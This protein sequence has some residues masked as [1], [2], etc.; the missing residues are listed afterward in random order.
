MNTEE[1]VPRC[2]QSNLDTVSMFGM[3]INSVTLSDVF[4]TVGRQIESREPGY[5]LT[6]NIDHVCE[7]QENAEF[8]DVYRNGFLVLA[9]GMP[10][11]WASK[12][13]GK[14]IKEKISG[15]DLVYW[16]SEYAAQKGYSIFFFGANE[17]IAQEASEILNEKYPNLKIA[18]VYFPPMGLRKAS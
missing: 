2:A 3:T 6:P 17:G 11:L 14:P 10:I 9:D 5:I 1:T 8:R 13:M 15:S 12:L 7:F 18:G 16:L 4:E